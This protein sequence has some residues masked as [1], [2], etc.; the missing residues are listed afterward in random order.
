MPYGSGSPQWQIEALRRLEIPED[1]QKAYGF[2][3]L[4]DA[5]GPIKTAIF[6]GTNAKLYDFD[7]GKRTDIGPRKDR[8]AL[9][10]EEYERNGPA[11]SNLCYGYVS[12][13][14]DCSAFA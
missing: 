8:F 7:I 6:S 3:P 5:I 4:G 10:K 1:M 12:G 14:V 13:P 11:P 2:K 9:M